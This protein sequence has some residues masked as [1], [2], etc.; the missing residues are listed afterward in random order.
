MDGDKKI[1]READAGLLQGEALFHAVFED[2]AI[3]IT[4]VDLNGRPVRCNPAL[5]RIL[6]YTG[7]E[8]RGMT[9]PEFTHP[10]DLK[11][12]YDLY[13]ELIS[14]K[15]DHYQI[16]KRYI[17]KD[18]QIVWARLTI[19][20]V[21]SDGSK[22]QYAVGMVEDITAQKLAQE[23]LRDSEEKSFKAFHGNPYPT[24]ITRRS[25]SRIIEVNQ[26]FADWYGVTIEEARGRTAFDF[27]IWPAKRDREE[28]L[29]LLE[30]Q[31][32]IT[33][34]PKSVELPSGEIRD[35]LLSIQPITIGHEDC[36]LAISTDITQQKNAEQALQRSEERLRRGLEAARMGTWEWDIRGDHIAWSEGV[37]SIFGLEPGQFGGTF[38]AFSR[39]VHEEDR[40]RVEQELSDALKD[41]A[42]HYYS[43]FRVRRADGSIHWLEGRGEVRRDAGGMPLTMLGTV[44]EVTGRKRAA[45]A[46]RSSEERLRATVENTPHVPIQ[47]YDANGKVLYWNHA[48]EFIYG[49]NAAEAQ[50]KTLDQLIF[51]AAEYARFISAL[52]EV[53]RTGK[54]FPPTEFRFHRRNG[55]KGV[56]LSTLFQIPRDGGEVCFV[57]MDVDVTE[58]KQ[59]EESLREAKE[60][61]LRSRDDFTRQ[62]IEAE[63]QE[64]Q[65]LAAEL[66]DGLGQNLSIIKNK[67]FTVLEKSSL[68]SAAAEQLKDI[69]RCTA[70]A[71]A[72]L[73]DLVRNLRP[74]QI[75]QL[76]L[77]DALRMMV[78]KTAQAS[79]LRIDRRIED[80]DDVLRGT[81]ATHVYRIVQEAL[82][83]MVKHA[84]A[85]RAELRLERDIHC[86]R[87]RLSDN[88][89]GFEVK[90]ATIR[91]GFGLTSI[92][93]RAQIL[94]GSMKIQSI[95]G[96]GT[97]LIVE[98][99]IRDE[100]LDKR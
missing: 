80:V 7:E 42:Y 45:A 76:G 53:E 34:Y 83:N 72:E 84:G 55:G 47:W 95:P 17:R 9:F 14:G 26:A 69:S 71:I 79:N 41:P 1:P 73:R 78:E 23:A 25:D 67:A 39:L 29:R 19:S 85:T 20:L 24:L 13:L 28:L 88:G 77:T 10:N 59:A 75:E 18:R 61:E 56:C 68:P 31:G 5:Q 87:L 94:G 38:D 33:H 62:L 91:G 57:C 58:Q 37:H 100:A 92:G 30:K 96:T 21:T 12:D 22:P 90:A 3:G 50:G 36:L 44:V 82:N 8:L 16:E 49:W 74:L 27:G 15:R 2:A 11:A 66:H 70:D 4:I 89:G 93:E 48:S 64:R 60:R 51:D 99:P 97:T 63:E 43:E 40:K 65:R 98:L 81:A 35:T 6:G 86:V 54:S 52:K 32:S 46:L